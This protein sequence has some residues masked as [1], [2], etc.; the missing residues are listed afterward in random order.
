MNVAAIILA[1]AGSVR[2]PGKNI[3]SFCGKPLL[4]WTIEQ[5][6][7]VK[8]INS[9]WISSDSDDILKLSEEYNCKTIRRPKELSISSASSESGWF[10]TIDVIDQLHSEKI[11]IVIAPQIT[12]PIRDSKDMTDALHKFEIEEWDFMLSCT[13]EG[14]QNGSFYIFRPDA[15]K[16][17]GFPRGKPRTVPQ[18]I[19]MGVFHQE[20]WKGYEIDYPIDL[21]ICEVLMRHFLLSDRYYESRDSK[22]EDDFYEKEYWHSIDPDGMKRNI[23][24]EYK[25]KL[26]DCKEELMYINNLSSGNILDV[27]CG[28]G[29]ILSGVLDTWNKY[30]VD[31]SNWAV[32]KAKEYGTIF[33][34]NLEQAHYENEFFDAV[35]LNHVI[36]HL[37]N[38]IEVLIEIRRILKPNGKLLLATPNFKCGLAKRFSHN[39]RLLHDKSHISLFDT[40]G[41][42]RLLTDLEFR[43][44]KISY[45]YFD[46]VHFTKKNLMRLFETKKISPPFYGNLI[47]IYSH[48]KLVK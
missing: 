5:L 27:G 18:D 24:K 39:F 21:K 11:D 44:E 48:K 7:K 13:P 33:Q 40:L 30:G 16:K 15:F 35:I 47:T 8:D 19:R 46:T 12:S 42:F 20:S 4:L 43:I 3:I 6:K 32:E 41:L 25:K 22:L 14:I 37:N 1:R 29:Y 26:E 2:I 10:H 36:E 17:F 34:G 31:I 38:P 9:I 28:V 23:E 45:P